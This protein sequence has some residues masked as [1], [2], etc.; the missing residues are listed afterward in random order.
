VRYNAA[1]FSITAEYVLNSNKNLVTA[2]GVPILR[3]R[4]TADRGY[5]QGEYRFN[6]SWGAMARFD[7]SYNN[8]H[9]R[10]GREFAAANPGSD[11][12]SRMSR[13]FTVGVNWRSG[14]HWGAWAEYHRIEGTSSLQAV[15][16]PAPGPANRWS[17][18]LLMAGYKF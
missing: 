12:K 6:S 15:D 2:G 17:L 7:A 14:E 13:D 5:L 3:T 16:N 8:R 1:K 10:S 9:D 11:R 4:V 18:W